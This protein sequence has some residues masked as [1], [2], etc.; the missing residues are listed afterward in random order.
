MYEP[1]LGITCAT[2]PGSRVAATRSS[3]R[4]PSMWVVLPDELTSACAVSADGEDMAGKEY[5]SQF[6]DPLPCT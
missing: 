2:A 3:G 5:S 1:S 4:T 6:W